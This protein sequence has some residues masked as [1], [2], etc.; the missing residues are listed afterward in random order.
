MLNN[1]FKKFLP[2]LLLVFLFQFFFFSFV[3]ADDSSIQFKPQ[4]SIPGFEGGPIG[5]TTAMIGE[6]IKALYIFLI[7]TLAILSVVMIA[8]AGITWLT[9]GGSA[10]KVGTAKAR[11]LGAIGGLALGLVSYVILQTINP[12]LVDFK[13]T[14]VSPVKPVGCCYSYIDAS[15]TSV[16]CDYLP[17]AE[18]TDRTYSEKSC[19]EISWC[20][21]TGCCLAY[22]EEYGVA[23]IYCQDTII[24]NCKKENFLG[25]L[26]VTGISFLPN[27]K[28]KKEEHW[29]RDSFTCE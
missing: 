29:G 10:E 9:A 20:G 11:I 17:K 23:A 21:G 16:Q 6:Y 3:L 18:C 13:I 5:N 26:T 28:C 25:E 2:I 4:V 7:S 24:S 27:K 14:D 15:Q 1:F 22:T 8:W 12:D 19:Y